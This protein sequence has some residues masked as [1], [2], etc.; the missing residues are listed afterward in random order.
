MLPIRLPPSIADA[1][2]RS[3]TPNGSGSAVDEHAGGDLLEQFGGDTGCQSERI[4][5]WVELDDVGTNQGCGQGRE[6]FE[7]LASGEASRLRM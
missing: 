4:T 2:M 6:N 3:V 1:P 5:Q 7:K